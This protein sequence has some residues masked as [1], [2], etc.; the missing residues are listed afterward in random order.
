MDYSK[1]R[2]LLWELIAALDTGNCDGLDIED[3]RLHARGGM[4]ATYMHETFDKIVDFSFLSDQDWQSLNEDFASMENA[5]DANRKF[6]VSNKGI[7][8]LM[9]WTLQGIQ[10]NAQQKPG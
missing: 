4:I 5:I 3:V 8:L 6:G 10:Q 1:Y 2:S 7:S 9:A